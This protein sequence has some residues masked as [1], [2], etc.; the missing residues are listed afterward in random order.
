MKLHLAALALVALPALPACTD[1]DD[2]D[3]GRPG[4]QPITWRVPCGAEG[5]WND[6]D[7]DTSTFVNDAR[8]HQIEATAVD[9]NGATY[10]HIT[11]GYDGDLPQWSDVVTGSL[12]TRTVITYDDRDRQIQ[13]VRTDRAL[14][15]G[16]S[17]FTITYAYDARSAMIGTDIDYL[18]PA[19]P[20]IH[21]TITG[22]LTT[23]QVSVDCLVSDPTVCDTYVFEQA[24]RD[25]AHWTLGTLDL[26]S[27]GGVDYRWERTLDAHGLELTFLETDFSIIATGVPSYR[28]ASRREPDGT[29]LG[30]TTDRYDADGTLIDVY[31]RD[32]HFT[33]PAARVAAPSIAR[34][35]IDDGRADV[36]ARLPRWRAD[37]R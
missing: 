32:Y 35:A 12:S 26:G 11:R 37:L 23:R 22:D 18:D 30:N 31:T 1:D 6:G 15:N 2:G 16:D 9:S 34:A 7:L 10:S 17:S 3:G 28:T 29:E 21:A 13:L 4:P 25:P 36:D 24:D 5:H 14:D 8:K 19:R 27:N 33:C 20:D